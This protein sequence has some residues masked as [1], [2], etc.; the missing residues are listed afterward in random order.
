LAKPR[1]LALRSPF[2]SS[3]KRYPA[4]REKQAVGLVDR[5]LRR[6]MLNVSPEGALFFGIEQETARST[7]ADEKRPLVVNKLAR[8]FL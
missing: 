4:N 6:A 5:A 7:L 1:A 3:G 2:Y 8:K